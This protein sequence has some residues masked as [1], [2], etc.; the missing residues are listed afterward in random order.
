ML[1]IFNQTKL[2]VIFNQNQLKTSF[3]KTEN[4]VS[5]YNEMLRMAGSEG[6]KNVNLL[7]TESSHYSLSS[8]Y[9]LLP[10]F[11]PTYLSSLSISALLVPALRQALCHMAGKKTSGCLIAYFPQ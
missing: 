10:T 3:R 5:L 7:M 4:L 8:T 6:S 2:L 11:L 1:V 9:H